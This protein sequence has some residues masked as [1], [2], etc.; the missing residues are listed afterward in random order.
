MIK[1]QTAEGL[2]LS[3]ITN[4]FRVFNMSFKVLSVLA[5][6]LAATCANAEDINEEELLEVI[7][8]FK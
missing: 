6:C 3:Q 2:G 4:R 5:I 8:D 1:S 7:I